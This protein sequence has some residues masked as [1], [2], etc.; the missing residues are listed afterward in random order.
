MAKRIVS[1]MSL[2][3]EIASALDEFAKSLGLSRS[4]ACNM[5]LKA[6]LG[7]DTTQLVQAMTDV[8]MQQGKEEAAQAV[9]IAING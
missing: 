1:N 6:T 8:L 2:E 4:S 5:I 3:P 9:D 7:G